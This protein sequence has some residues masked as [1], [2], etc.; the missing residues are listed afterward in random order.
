MVG[1][2]SLQVDKLHFDSNGANVL[3]AQF[4][5]SNAFRYLHHHDGNPVLTG[6]TSR[7]L[8]Q[9]HSTHSL[10]PQL[11]DAPSVQA[12]GSS[13]HDQNMN[14]DRHVRVSAGANIEDTAKSR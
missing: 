9:L 12:T 3:L 14:R 11:A 1:P 5:I 6:E 2:S 10:A 13:Q 7:V 4:Q 8:L